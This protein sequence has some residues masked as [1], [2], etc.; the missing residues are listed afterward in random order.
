MKA[1]SEK[2]NEMSE[3]LSQR[4][5]CENM[6]ESST[7][8]PPNY[9]V[10]LDEMRKLFDSCPMPG[11]LASDVLGELGRKVDTILKSVGK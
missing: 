1:E 5:V 4:K 10:A 8:S 2:E 6:G 7:V 3:R 9:E 11:R